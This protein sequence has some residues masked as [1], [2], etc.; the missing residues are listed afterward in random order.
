[1]N[2]DKKFYFKITL[3]LIT[4]FFVWHF[5]SPEEKNIVLDPEAEGRQL[6]GSPTALFNFVPPTFVVL[7]NSENTFPRRNWSV[8]ALEL[9]A[10]AALAMRADGGR[11]YYN[12]NMEIRRSVAS[13][14][15]LMTAIV[16]LENYNLDEII[17][18]PI[19]AVK[20][21]GSRGDLRLSEEITR[22]A[23]LNM[24]LIDSSNDAAMA[25]AG[26]NP[27]F[28]SLMNKKT[29]KLGLLN[30]HFT[31][32]DGLDE[33]NNYS[34]AFDIAGIF[35]YLVSNYPSISEI[36]KTKNMVIYSAD[37]KI[38][39][40]LKNTNALL[41]AISEIKAG[42]TGYTEMAGGSLALLISNFHF[43]DKNNIIT[44]VLGSPDRFGESEK[45]IRWLKGAYIWER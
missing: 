10:E 11:V 12:K 37:G 35:S 14:T 33:D 40:R 24:I 23:L 27:K 26:E 3:I 44:V 19:T 9:N 42:K 20:R 21:E 2:N 4:A 1:M 16:V 13:L 29:K 41:G 32:P 31:N 36:L 17:K 18:V 15:K 45:L 22:R 6:K 7:G 8:P 34:T 28:V 43:G 5:G 30:T 39:H 25:L 38:T